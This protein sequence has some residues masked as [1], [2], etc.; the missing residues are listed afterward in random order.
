[1]SEIEKKLK[2]KNEKLVEIMINNK[3]SKLNLVSCGNSIATGF[4]M[5]GIS[6][7]L[8]Y[9]NEGIKEIFTEK[10]VELNRYHFSR[11][12]DNNDEH[13]L[14]FLFN[15]TKLGE[16]NRLNRFDI[17]NM[18]FEGLDEEKIEQYYPLNDNTTLKSLFFEDSNTYNNN[19]ASS[20]VVYN[21]VTGSFLDN[22][23][24]NGKHYFT[25]GIKRDCVSIEAFLKYIQGLNRKENKNV[26]VYLCGAPKLLGLSDLLM[27]TRLKEITRNYANAT[28]VD[29]IPKQLFYKREN[30][31]TVFDVHYNEEEYMELNAQIISSINANYTKNKVIVD[32][33]KE[34]YELNTNYQLGS[35]K[36]ED[37]P[38]ISKTIIQK[39]ISKHRTMLEKENANMQELLKEA[40][41]YLINRFCY[42]FYYIGK[43]QIK[44]ELKVK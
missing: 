9:R 40:R 4:S 5:N 34:L 19:L 27:N 21:G 23:M 30:G 12:E 25:Y 28:F 35:V 6:K 1:M 18:N 32:I 7:P 14:D 42:D 31:S 13:T 43:K 38:E 24:R 11:A 41:T 29:N 20:V 37:I 10:G 22:V 17:A 15:N 26:Q 8:L 2:L 16:I 39:I 3:I 36:L 33:D 44:K